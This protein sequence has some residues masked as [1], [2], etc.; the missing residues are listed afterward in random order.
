[1][2]KVASRDLRNHTADVLARARSGEVMEVTV[3]GEVVA[4]VHPPRTFRPDCFARADLA[5][6]LARAQ[7]DPGLRVELAELAGDSTADLE[8]P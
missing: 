5:D 3:H 2:G 6:R 7:A 8:A 4:E 1:M